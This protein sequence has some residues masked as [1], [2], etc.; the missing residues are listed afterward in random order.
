MCIR[1]RYGIDSNHKFR[2]AYAHRLQRP[3]PQSLN[4]FLTYVDQQNVTAGNPNLKPQ[5]TDSFELGYE[6]S[7]SIINYQVRGYYRKNYNVITQN[8]FFLTPG[9]LETTSQNSGTSENSGL[10]FNFSGKVT[11]QLT[12]STNA[13]LAHI[14]LVNSNIPGTQQADTLSGRLSF[15]YMASLNDHF[16]FFTFTSGKQLT[17]QGFRSPFSMSNFSYSHK[18]TPKT[19]FIMSVSDPF[20]S[21][22]IKNLTDTPTI[23]SSTAASFAGPTV[24]IGLSFILGGPPKGQPQGGWQGMGGGMRGGPGGPNGY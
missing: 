9:V 17:G 6:V 16:Q 1:D 11:K 14:E 5:E 10:E 8:S 19:S 24:Y 12:I 13:N 22:K 18:I 3:S 2:F 20:R 7:G 21:M 4:P 23:M 15:D